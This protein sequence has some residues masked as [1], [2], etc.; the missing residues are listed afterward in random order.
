M[1]LVPIHE[2]C[3]DLETIMI[4]KLET[5]LE[6]YDLSQLTNENMNDKVEVLEA[7]PIAR[8]GG[9]KPDQIDLS[10]LLPAIG[11]VMMSEDPAQR[12]VLG[13]G[14]ASNVGLSKD[15]FTN[16]YKSQTT[17]ERWRGGLLVSDTH[18][19]EIDQYFIN[20]P[21]E[22]ELPHEE[23]KLIRNTQAKISIWTHHPTITRILRHITRAVIIDL[24]RELGE[25]GFKI[26]NFGGVGNLYNYEFGMT[27][28]GF[29]WNITM[30][31][32]VAN[33]KIDTEVIRIKE[34]E[35][36][37]TTLDP[38]LDDEDSN[39][40]FGVLGREDQWVEKDDE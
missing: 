24:H 3:A 19:D 8:I 36:A 37:V 29:D 2:F 28:Y 6:E 16:V 17:K 14:H 15:K 26:L 31:N 27:L 32:V 23:K 21:D 40:S 38:A 5:V 10:T 13:V 20:N 34:I 30:F 18:I 7:H 12:N 33:R 22:E 11:V 9:M 4:S 35:E 1:A 25:V 39:P